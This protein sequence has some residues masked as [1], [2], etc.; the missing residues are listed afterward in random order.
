MEKEGD[1]HVGPTHDDDGDD[2]DD[3]D[4][5]NYGDDDNN[6]DPDDDVYGEMGNSLYIEHSHIYHTMLC[7]VK[8]YLVI[9]NN[10]D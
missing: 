9:D 4:N 6:G 10:F 2:D 7:W 5:D 1:D 8:I 3:N